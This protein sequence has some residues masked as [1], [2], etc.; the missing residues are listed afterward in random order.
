MH[1]DHCGIELHAQQPGGWFAGPDE[2]SDCPKSPRGH[3]VDGQAR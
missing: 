1:C 3:E 2:T